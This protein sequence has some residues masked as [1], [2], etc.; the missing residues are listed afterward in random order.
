MNK[1][2]LLGRL[3]KDPELKFAPGTGTAICTFTLAVKRM[4][5]D[6]PADFINC[7]AFNKNAENIA[8]YMSKGR[9]I[10]IEG[11]IKTGSYTAKDGTKRY[12][13]DINVEK[14]DFIG[15]ANQNGNNQEYQQNNKNSYSGTPYMDGMTPVDDGEMPF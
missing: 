4:K 2:I 7:V 6:D 5:K 12:T 3:T 8:Q 15:S 13:T 1:V 10:A 9:Q 11:N 14:F